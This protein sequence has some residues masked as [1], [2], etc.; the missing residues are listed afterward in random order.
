MSVTVMSWSDAIA[1]ANEERLVHGL[2][3]NGFSRACFDDIFS[4]SALVDRA[5]FLGLSEHCRETF[6]AL[7]TTDF[8]EVIRALKVASRLASVYLPKE[9]ETAAQM[10]ADA[11]QLREVLVNAIAGSH[12]GWP[13]DVEPDSYAACKAFLANFKRIYTLNYDLLL[14]WAFM[15]DEIEPEL[16]CDDGF[17]HPDGGEEDYVAWEVDQS[18]DQKIYYLHG[19]LHLFDSGS[20]LQKYTWSRTGV[21]LIEQI[22][23]A[24]A[25]SKFPLFVSEGTSEEKL[26]RIKHHGYLHRGIAS[27]G[28]INGSL[29]V[30]GMS[31]GGSDAHIIR[32]LERGRISRV[33]VSLF[34]NPDEPYNKS[35]IERASAMSQHRY[36]RAARRRGRP[37][38]LD[39]Y[40][41]D[42]QSANVWG[43]DC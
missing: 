26:A 19:A 8:E 33:Y 22:R 24:L 42:A 12:P 2:L 17:R 14:Y 34:G 6:R 9:Q 38:A 43:N 13:G 40:F 36:E 4:Y 37:R 16:Q 27:I 35:I 21:R 23:A 32:V 39:I 11:N 7:E 10:A 28:S 30:H 5:D 18:Y 3:G 1:H 41:Y 29:I 15:Q 20:Q 25:E 31:F